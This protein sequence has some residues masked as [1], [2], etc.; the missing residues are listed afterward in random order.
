MRAKIE[1]EEKL[2]EYNARMS[3]ENEVCSLKSEIDAIRQNRGGDARD[4]NESL[5]G[6]QACTADREKE[7]SRLKELLEAEKRRADKER[8]SAEKERKRAAEAWKLVEVEKSTT[9]EKG[10]QIA[11]VEA[12]KAE[13]YRTR[14]G[15]LEK[16]ANEVKTKLASQISA[17]KEATK[18]FEAEKK[19]ILAEKRNAELG[20]TKAKEMLEIEKQKVN[21]EKRRADAEMV[22]VEEQKVLA[23]DNWRK[24]MEEKHLAD[25]MS[26]Q[27][28]E[29]KQTIE[30][31][32]QK[33]TELSSLRKP[34]E[35][36]GVSTEISAKAESTNVKLLKSQL[37]LEKLRAKCARQNFK[38][39]ASRHGILRHELGRLKVDFIQLLHRLDMLDASFSPF[40]GRHDQTKVG[41][42]LPVIY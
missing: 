22:K 38:L 30:N 34:I 7:I 9:A 20:M 21:E 11:K 31:L 15:K 28:E 10:M 16:D 3:L 27:V 25:Q 40:T 13:E 32:K 37:K 12:E 14:L 23:E 18:K 29:D 2:K 24:F 1:T 39:E 33:I 8:K 36:A 6:F 17:F 35:M 5:E 26:L 42:T 41:F 19:K 4:G